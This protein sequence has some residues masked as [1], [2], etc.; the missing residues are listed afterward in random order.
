MRRSLIKPDEL[1][2]DTR[3]DEAFVILRGAK[4]LRCGR[5]IYFRR[6]E[7]SAEVAPSRG[8]SQGQRRAPPRPARP[9]ARRET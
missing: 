2:Q 9:G 6:P 5:A 4:P 7:M 3:T 8:S 1:L